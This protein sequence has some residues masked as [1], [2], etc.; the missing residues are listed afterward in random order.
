MPPSGLIK[1]PGLVVLLTL[2]LT[3]AACG[4]AA[5]PTVLPTVE[6]TPTPATTSS[7][8]IPPKAH[9]AQLFVERDVQLAT[10]KMRKVL[11]LRPRCLGTPP[12]R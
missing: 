6:P 4:A 2:I 7:S 1:L 3:A 11:L 10:G 5:T 9:G 8:A 12:S